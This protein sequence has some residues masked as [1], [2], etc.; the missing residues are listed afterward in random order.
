MQEEVV[1]EPVRL[2]KGLPRVFG[3]GIKRKAS[4]H[5]QGPPCYRL[6]MPNTA[7]EYPG[8]KSPFR[9][10][11][12][13]SQAP[14]PDHCAPQRI[15]SAPRAAP[16]SSLPPS[17]PCGAST[18]KNGPTTPRNGNSGSATPA[19]AR[20]RRYLPPTARKLRLT[21][22][23]TCVTGHRPA[24]ESSLLSNG[25]GSEPPDLLRLRSFWA[26]PSWLRLNDRSAS[27]GI[28]PPTHGSSLFHAHGRSCVSR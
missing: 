11:E 9:S 7:V 2:E 21:Q 5:S 3:N 28:Q 8:P 12:L 18:W 27:A 10:Q 4:C 19:P 6:F 20:T 22:V 1:L 26:S 23:V 14:L 24:I 17:R 25:R 13:V 16:A 15:L